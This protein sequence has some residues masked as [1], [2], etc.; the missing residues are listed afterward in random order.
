VIR[1]R[2][3]AMAP[4]HA[5]ESLVGVFAMR[6][7]ERSAFDNASQQGECGVN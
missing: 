7:P 2:D 3:M 6:L 4:T 1:S 5:H